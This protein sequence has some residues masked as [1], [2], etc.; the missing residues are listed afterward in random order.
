M[1]AFQEISAGRAYCG[2]ITIGGTFPSREEAKLF[3]FAWLEDHGYD[4]FFVEDDDAEDGVDFMTSRGR[5]L[6][7]FAVN[8]LQPS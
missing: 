5:A 4:A 3:A 1:Y 6:I 7:Q 2:P 8:R